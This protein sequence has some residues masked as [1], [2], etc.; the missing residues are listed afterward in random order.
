[1]AR[2]GELWQIMIPNLIRMSTP[3]LQRRQFETEQ[4]FE[5]LEPIVSSGAK[6]LTTD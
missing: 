5:W 1:M 2:A 3:G 4:E 6:N